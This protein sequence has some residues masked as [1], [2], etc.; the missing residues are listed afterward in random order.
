MA[1]LWFAD[2]PVGLGV[3]EVGMGG[4]WDA[5]NLIAGEVAVITPIG[6]DHVAELGPR[7]ED[8]AG[9]KA[10]IIK[11]GAT[12]VVRSQDPAAALVLAR[13]A[14]D[15]G[16]TLLHE[17]ADWEVL[18]P[19]L[20]VGGQ[21]FGLRTPR[22]TYEDLYIPV[23]GT[24]AA[25]NAAAGAIAVET[26]TGHTID[27]ATLR[28]GLADVR[29][30]GRLDVVGHTP[31]VVLDGAHNPPGAEA[32]AAA[33]GQTFRWE[34]LHVVLA[35]SGNKDVAGVV[36][37]LAAL[38]DAVYAAPNDSVR[39]APAAEVAAA[40]RA[41][42][43]AT[44]RSTRASPPRWR[45]PGTRPG[46]ATWCSSPARCS[47]SPTRSARSPRPDRARL[48]L[49]EH[50]HLAKRRPDVP[51]RGHPGRDRDHV[52]DADGHVGP[53]LERDSHGYLRARPR[54]RVVRGSRSS[55][56]ASP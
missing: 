36:G 9:E 28:A 22:A 37:P 17:G 7:V 20:A 35:V 24:Y 2:K 5:T 3:F 27:E 4:S 47:P 30:P 26:L 41:A 51:G 12:A 23:F 1:Y 11:E 46:R 10:G 14:D 18:D 13:R 49:G 19:L 50:P 32:L 34:R 25:A 29:T 8:I 52:P 53:V 44:S 48:P 16:A 33:L 43:A 55:V 45:R 54:P 56:A 38:A 31:A 15:V 6:M 40:S 42:G 39:S 21:S